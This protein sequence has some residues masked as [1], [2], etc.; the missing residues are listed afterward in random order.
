MLPI[1]LRLTRWVLLYLR[2][3]RGPITFLEQLVGIRVLTTE[4]KPM[5]LS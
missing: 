1:Q 4:V 5:V 3:V 2:E